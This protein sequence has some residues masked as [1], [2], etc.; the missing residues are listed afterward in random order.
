MVE[1]NLQ[2]CRVMQGET[3]ITHLFVYLSCTKR[4]TLSS[5]A[6]PAGSS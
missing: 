3:V 5:I 1:H 4:L 6:W 2:S